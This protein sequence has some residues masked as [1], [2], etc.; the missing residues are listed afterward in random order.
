MAFKISWPRFP[1]ICYGDW[2]IMSN[3][4]E[5]LSL[6]VF[7]SNESFPNV[8]DAMLCPHTVSQKSAIKVYVVLSVAAL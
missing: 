3:K 2:I 6:F 8:C 7:H 4:A 1:M 5:V